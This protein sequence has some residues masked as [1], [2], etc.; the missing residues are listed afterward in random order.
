M[1]VTNDCPVSIHP[2]FLVL[3]SSQVKDT[4]GEVP[5]ITLISTLRTGV[6][7]VLAT[8]LTTFSST[9]NDLVLIVVVLPAIVRLPA[10]YKSVL[11]FSEPEIVAPLVTFRV[12]IV[13]LVEFK[14]PIVA[15]VT[16]R[17]P[18]VSL[19]TFRVAIVAPVV[20]LRVAVLIVPAIL[21]LPF[22]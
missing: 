22:E 8:R 21:A 6:P 18:T 4:F 12:P 17:V 2:H 7:T 14:V 15:L 3:T 13:S 20:T 5:R 19:V 11:T 1:N 16:F 9:Y 10:T